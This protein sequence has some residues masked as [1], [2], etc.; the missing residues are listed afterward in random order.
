[1]KNDNMCYPIALRNR[2]LGYVFIEDYTLPTE[3]QQKE[4]LKYGLKIVVQRLLK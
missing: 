3:D 1:M 2:T 4:I